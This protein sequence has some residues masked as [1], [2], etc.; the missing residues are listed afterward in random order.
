M[1]KKKIKRAEDKYTRV[2]EIDCDS[3][4]YLNDLREWIR[5]V[6]DPH[7][8]VPY[9][10]ELMELNRQRISIER[11]MQWKEWAAESDA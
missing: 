3:E 11:L 5:V 4:D 9:D 8:N 6:T 10:R 7:C 2:D 1:A